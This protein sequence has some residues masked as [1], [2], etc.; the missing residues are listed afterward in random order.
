MGTD[1]A[2]LAPAPTLGVLADTLDLWAE[3]RRASAL[4]DPYATD[5][6]I[7]ITSRSKPGVTYELRVAGGIV[8]CTC[9]GFSYRGNCTHARDVATGGGG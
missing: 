9:P 8:T 3:A 5:R 4:S 7:T 2:R 1:P 6:V